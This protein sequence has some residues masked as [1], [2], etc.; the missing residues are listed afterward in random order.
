MTSEKTHDYETT[1]NG[2]STPVV[3]GLYLFW[4]CALQ[5]A[6]VADIFAQ[7]DLDTIGRFEGASSFGDAAAKGDFNGDGIGD[8]AIGSP[9]ENRVELIFGSPGLWAARASQATLTLTP[10]VTRGIVNNQFGFALGACDFDGDGK[11]ELVV[12]APATTVATHNAA[13]AVHIYSILPNRG[14]S[15]P[16][17]LE[18]TLDDS[19]FPDEEAGAGELF[20]RALI[21][22]SIQGNNRCDIAVGVPGQEVGGNAAAGAVRLYHRVSQQVDVLPVRSFTALDFE[23]PTRENGSFGLALAIGAFDRSS[24]SH[25]GL[26]ISEPGVF[27]E[28]DFGK[29]YVDFGGFHGLNQ[30]TTDVLSGVEGFGLALAA[31]DFDGDGIDELAIGDPA[32]L[33]PTVGGKRV[34]LL[35]IADGNGPDAPHFETVVTLD[36]DQLGIAGGSEEFDYFA[37]RISVGD[38][39]RNGYEDLVVSSSGENSDRGRVDVLYG[40][41]DGFAT[42]RVQ[43]V[44][45]EDFDPLLLTRVLSGVALGDLDGSG[46]DDLGLVLEQAD[47]RGTPTIRVMQVSPARPRLLRVT[48]LLTRGDLVQLTDETREVGWI[49]TTNRDETGRLAVALQFTDGSEAILVEDGAGGWR[50]IFDSARDFPSTDH[51]VSFELNSNDHF[52]AHI[53]EF[54]RGVQGTDAI[55]SHN[56]AVARHGDLNPALPRAVFADL[57]HPQLIG[58]SVWFVSAGDVFRTTRSGLEL[59]IDRTAWI[60]RVPLAEITGLSVSRDGS[61]VGIVG[62]DTSDRDLAALN[63]QVLSV[64]GDAMV[65]PA[66]GF[67]SRVRNISVEEREW[68]WSSLAEDSTGE[69]PFVSTREGSALFSPL[70]LRNGTEVVTYN[71]ASR[72]TGNGELL[73]L[74][75]RFVGARRWSL[76]L[77]CQGKPGG[78]LSM[79]TGDAIDFDGDRVMD[80][81][82]RT[83]AAADPASDSLVVLGTLVG[84]VSSRS[85]MRVTNSWRGGLACPLFDDGFESGDTSSW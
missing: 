50:E 73:T 19:Q 68:A 46:S 85:L 81:E 83:I 6:V 61:Q 32:G 44:A 55:F 47:V 41:L 66:T 36:Q 57:G 48:K 63:G 76:V 45:A 56:G 58:S 22:G 69:Y 37:G 17:Q 14:D 67:V 53:Q 30:A 11:D 74:W 42:D 27:A 71:L 23:E 8:V 34:G 80:A 49:F 65:A 16:F 13:G 38:F 43:G 10:S 9:E 82:L 52:A 62:S 20:G 39:D 18:K 24:P 51:I 3:L 78:W 25:A 33:K 4:I 77:S 28:Q 60:P 70:R 40:H 7:I 59:A 35:H 5:I 26:A 12:G 21:V 31:G 2:A 64:E 75:G 29:V 1:R 84:D 72:L 54:R 15:G 79:T